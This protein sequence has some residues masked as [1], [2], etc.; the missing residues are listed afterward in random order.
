M[1]RQVAATELSRLLSVLSH[2]VR[3]RI[4]EELRG[5]E[6]DVNGLMHT[7]GIAH[8]AV[9]QHLSKLRDQRVVELRREGRHTFY[10]LHDPSLAEW[11][12]DGLAF[13]LGDSERAAAVGKAVTRARRLWSAPL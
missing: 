6:Q 13:V 1:F 10:R 7:L 9:S 3:L 4:V 5:G 11:L 2:P 12:V 8:S